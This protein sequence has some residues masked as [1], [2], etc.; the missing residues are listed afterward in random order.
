MSDFSTRVRPPRLILGLRPAVSCCSRSP[1]RPVYPL[2]DR[3]VA[4]Q[5]FPR[6]V[7]GNGARFGADYIQ[8]TYRSLPS[9]I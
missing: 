3:V 8:R 6:G 7:Q 9:C 1:P 2:W 5:A 4:R